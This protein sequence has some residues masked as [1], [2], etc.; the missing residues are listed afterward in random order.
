MVFQYVALIAAAVWYSP[1]TWIGESS[2]VHIHLWGSIVLGGLVVALP[3]AFAKTR[4]GSVESK[5]TIAIA[6]ALISALLIHVFGGR[7]EAHFH[8]FGVLAFLSFY[9]DWRILLS[10]A[11]IV[12][13]DHFIRGLFWPL[14]VFGDAD[15]GQWRWLEHGAWVVF[16]CGILAGAC[17]NGKKQLL[18]LAQRQAELEFTQLAIESKVSERTAELQSAYEHIEKEA[19]DRSCA[20]TER[21]DLVAQLVQSQKLE[22]VGQ[23]ADGIAHEINTPMQYLGDNTHFLQDAMV[24]IVRIIRLSEKVA[25]SG[26]YAQGENQDVVLLLDLLDSACIEDLA[27]DL[28]E[29]LS[30]SLEGIE[31]VR[32]IVGAMKDFSH[33]GQVWMTPVD[34]NKAIESVVMVA[35]HEWKYVATVETDLDPNLGLVPCVLCEL[36]Q[37][38]LN[39]VVN[40][41]HALGDDEAREAK[42]MGVI[43][44]T[45]LRH[46]DFAEIRISD[47][48]SG[49]PAE[50]REKMFELFFTT[51]EVGRG[52]GQGLAMAH[53]TIV[54]K[55][56]GSIDC[57]SE[58]GVG[59]TFVLKLPLVQSSME[60]SAGAA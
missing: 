21:D 19:R 30:Q 34:L 51:K 39:L 31:R 48:G 14:S 43:R 40:A 47:T 26:S 58:V 9:R 44:F 45:T 52:T 46:A 53:N 38:L 3:L 56:G 54:V 23:L 60:E 5:Y 13:V 7:T 27:Q 8:V 18:A 24:D 59:T 50:V 25:R 15:A 4:A 10:A 37:T 57:E 32:S 16:E 2:R 11:A 29:A 55:H 12:T 22:A 20:E 28:S 6:Q 49:M 36:N 41:A 35:S 17:H 1:L 42:G 33:P